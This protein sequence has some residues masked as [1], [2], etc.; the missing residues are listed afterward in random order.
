M[1]IRGRLDKLEQRFA[2]EPRGHKYLYWGRMGDYEAP[3]WA[4]ALLQARA[5]AEQPDRE[6]RCIGVAVADD[7]RV[8]GTFGDG[9]REPHRHYLVTPDGLQPVPEIP[10]DV[11]DEFHN[12]SPEVMREREKGM[13]T[14]AFTVG[15][16]SPQGYGDE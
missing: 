3:A 10:Q 4:K 9:Y 7:G 11:E 6:W 14:P 2:P 12:R 16:D 15:P 1:S 5:D 8:F 13:E